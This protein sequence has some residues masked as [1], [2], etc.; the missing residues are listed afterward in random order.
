M[1]LGMKIAAGMLAFLMSASLLAGCGEKDVQDDV[2][3]DGQ[4]GENDTADSG[5]RYDYDLS[6]YVK[7]DSYKGIEIDKY[8]Y[9]VTDKDVET[10]ILLARSNYAV[11]AEKQDAI[12]VSDQVNIDYTG[13]MD[14]EQFAGGT[15]QGYDLTIGSGQFIAGFEDGLV[16]HKAGETVTLDLHFPSPYPNA[17]ELSGKPVQFVV[18]I[19]KVF[20]QALPEYNDA[21]VKEHYDYDTVAEFEK[22]IYD[23]MVEHHENGRLSYKVQQVWSK[24]AEMAE[25]TEYPEKEFLS[26]Y[27]DHVNYYTNLA[28]QEGISLN[29]Y[30]QKEF[31][32]AVESFYEEIR[33]LVQNTMQQEM[34]L[35]YVAQKENITI[36]DEEYAEGAMEYASYYGLS[37]VEE[38]EQYYSK[39][40]IAQS[41]LFDKVYEFLANNAVEK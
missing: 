2:P 31:G 17:P 38:L 26:M 8:T 18:K 32:L 24:I 11:A 21:F 1:K 7:L 33:A 25:I 39:E 19:N 23:A 5:V 41:V 34:I 6:Q 22:A 28:V 35:F 27:E 16:G 10:Q 15:A 36:T 12:A 30:I 29:E 4:P 37:S 13:Y 14:G 3:G 20:E 40:N 9:S